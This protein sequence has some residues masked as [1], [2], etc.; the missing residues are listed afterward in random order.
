MMP[1]ADEGSIGRPITDDLIPQTPVTATAVWKAFMQV[2]GEQ[3][4]PVDG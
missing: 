4:L 2:A 3:G 1:V